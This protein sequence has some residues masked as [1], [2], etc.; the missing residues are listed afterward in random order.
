VQGKCARADEANPA[1]SK[2]L[3]DVIHRAMSV[4]KMKRFASMDEFSEAIGA[5]VEAG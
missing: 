4:D 3:S 5:A 1:I 2:L